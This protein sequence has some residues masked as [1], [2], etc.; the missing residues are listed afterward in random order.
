MARTAGY[1]TPPRFLT[2]KQALELGGNVRNGEHGTK[3]YFV[4]QLQVRDQDA[5]D[6]TSTRLFP[7]MREYTVFNVEQCQNLP[8]SVKTGKPMRVRNPNVRDDLADAFLQSTG[9]EIR[10]GSEAYYVP[11]RDFISRSSTSTRGPAPAS[12]CSTPTARWRGSAGVV[13]VGFTGRAGVAFQQMACLLGRSLRATL[14][15]ATR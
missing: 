7:M 13:Q 10:E 2:F 1:R 8:D 5:D 15:I 12:Q 9:A 11:N 14:H 6:S 4:K 3:V